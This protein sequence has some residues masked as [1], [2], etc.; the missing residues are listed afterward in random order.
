MGFAPTRF[1]ASDH[2]GRS[3]R[4]RLQSCGPTIAGS[5]W[6][7]LARLFA[8]FPSPIPAFPDRSPRAASDITATDIWRGQLNTSGVT[9]DTIVTMTKHKPSLAH[10]RNVRDISLP[11]RWESGTCPKSAAGGVEREMPSSNA[12]IKAIKLIKVIEFL[13]V[14]KAL[15]VIK[16][17]SDCPLL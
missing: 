16:V 1:F 13:K 12:A 14:I 6:S 17:D 5:S 9:I 7:T 10:G 4:S 2:C 15:K 11:K 3:R 8:R